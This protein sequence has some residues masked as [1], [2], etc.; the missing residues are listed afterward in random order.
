MTTATRTTTPRTCL[1][2]T[3]WTTWCP[4]PSTR[5]SF[6]HR[7]SS[8]S[9]SSNNNGFRFLRLHHR[10]RLPCRRHRHR[11]SEWPR[12]CR[13]GLLLLLLR[14]RVMLLLGVLLPVV[15]G[16]VSPWRIFGPRSRKLP[17]SCRQPAA[18]AAAAGMTLKAMVPLLATTIVLP[19][20]APSHLDI[21]PSTRIRRTIPTPIFMIRAAQVP[22]GMRI[23]GTRS[24][25]PAVRS[26]IP[27]ARRR[28]KGQAR[29]TDR[30]Y[31]YRLPPLPL[32]AVHVPH[33]L[34]CLSI[35]G[36]TLTTKA[37]TRRDRSRVS[38]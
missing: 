23:I 29:W 16:S 19:V 12:R 7:S 36:T 33:L 6:H 15:V 31:M 2:D 30:S 25:L 8:S 17:T 18:A 21:G 5:A 10:C 32:P 11:Y 14:V 27:T 28:E 37:A 35:G 22:M 20:I 26:S 24:R 13:W 1:P 3:P 34:L 4:L 9:S 38:R